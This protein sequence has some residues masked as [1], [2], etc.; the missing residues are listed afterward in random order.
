MTET[1]D[2]PISDAISEAISGAEP[3]EAPTDRSW[4]EVENV[5]GGENP[6]G[7]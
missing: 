2:E 1:P 5:R 6:V 7:E 4:L 3:K